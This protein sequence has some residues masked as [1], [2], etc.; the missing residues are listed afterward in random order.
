MVRTRVGYAGGTKRNPTYHG[1][2]DHSEAVQ[3]DYDPAQITYADLLD[4]FWAQHNPI[5]Q[6]RSRQYM[7]I[8][9]VE[10]ETER[11]L[12][13]ESLQREEQRRGTKVYTRIEP[14][15]E[16]YPAE[17]YHQKYFLQQVPML[18]R[19]YRAIYDNTCDWVDSTAVAR[20]NGYLAGYGTMEGLKAQIHDLGL[21]AAAE[22]KLLEL[23][24]NRLPAGAAVC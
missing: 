12:A 6:P 1:L 23:A 5:H 24:Q 19:E 21:S 15:G 3:I 22:A 11:R 9:F 4:A 17:D 14:A 8:I 7:S 20:V 13:M 16:F 10:N 2:G 18:L